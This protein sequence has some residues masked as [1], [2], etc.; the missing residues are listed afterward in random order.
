M[1]PTISG[2]MQNYNKDF[3]ELSIRNVCKL[4]G[5]KIYRLLSVNGFDGKNGQLCTCN[6]FALKQFRNKLCEMA[7]LLPTDMDKA[8]PEQLVDMMSTGVVAKVT[9]PEG[10]KRG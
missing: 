5:V 10:G 9:N 8:Y 4:S 6:M 7:H 2:M 1:Q 3:S